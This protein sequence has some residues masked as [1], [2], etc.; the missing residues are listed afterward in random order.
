[1]DALPDAGA[2]HLVSNKN[3]FAR[4]VALGSMDQHRRVRL[5][6]A[7]ALIAPVENTLKV[8]ALIENQ[9]HALSAR[10][11]LHN[12]MMVEPFVYHASPANTKT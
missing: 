2:M 11:D 1:M 9:R 4:I 12:K 3:R 5:P 10:L 6:L 8:L 7:V